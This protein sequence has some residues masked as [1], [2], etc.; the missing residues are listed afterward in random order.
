MLGGGD[1]SPRHLHRPYNITGVRTHYEASG[2]LPVPN[3]RC[4]SPRLPPGSG[5]S[6]LGA[7]STDINDLRSFTSWTSLLPLGSGTLAVDSPVHIHREASH[8]VL[9]KNFKT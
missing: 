7:E 8:T 2:F 9:A 4:I 6:A 1:H 5:A 3:A